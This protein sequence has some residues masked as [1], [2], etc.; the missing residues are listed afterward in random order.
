MKIAVCVFLI[1]QACKL[2]I[3]EII[4]QGHLNDKVPPPPYLCSRLLGQTFIFNAELVCLEAKREKK[5]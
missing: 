5:C 2:L 4:V 3:K 1:A